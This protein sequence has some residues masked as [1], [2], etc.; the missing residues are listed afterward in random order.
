MVRDGVATKLDCDEVLLGLLG[1]FTDALRNFLRFTIADA[2]FTLLV[3]DDDKCS[4]AETSTA[5]DHF[6]ATVNVDNFFDEFRCFFR[7]VF[8]RK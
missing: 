7:F 5:F 8:L 6:S 2:D 1:T 3:T 4:K